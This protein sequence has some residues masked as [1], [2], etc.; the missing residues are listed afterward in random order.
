MEK[1]KKMDETEY[2]MSSPRNKE[3]LD[4]AIQDFKDG[5]KIE[6]HD[7]IEDED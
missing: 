2:L 6:E 4:Q 1:R 7:L 5:K 3:R